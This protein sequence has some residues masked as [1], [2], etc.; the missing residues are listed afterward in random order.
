MAR[1]T[2]TNYSSGEL[3]IADDQ[4]HSIRLNRETAHRVILSARMHSIGEFFKQVPQ[5][6]PQQ[7]IVRSL[8]DEVDKRKSPTERWNLKEKFARLSTLAKDYAPTTLSEIVE[9]V[10]WN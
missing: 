3:L 1:I 6:I 2:L 5:L 4:G 8:L 10:S 7:E 9:K